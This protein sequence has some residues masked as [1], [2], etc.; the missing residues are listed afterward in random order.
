M[1]TEYHDGV[2]LDELL[3]I[4][5]RYWPLL[6]LSVAICLA[7]TLIYASNLS[8]E[9]VFET[10]FELGYLASSRSRTIA[11]ISLIENDIT[12]RVVATYTRNHKIGRKDL[13]IR[14]VHH[15]HGNLFSLVSRGHKSAA[16]MHKQIH[17]EIIEDVLRREKRAIEEGTPALKERLHVVRAALK[18][19]EA[20]EEAKVRFAELSDATKDSTPEFRSL[21][22]IC[23]PAGQNVDR[24]FSE[25]LLEQLCRPDTLQSRRD[26]AKLVRNIQIDLKRA[27]G[28]R[29]DALTALLRALEAGKNYVTMATAERKAWREYQAF[30]LEERLRAMQT[31]KTVGFTSTSTTSASHPIAR[32]WLLALAIGLAFGMALALVAETL[33][34]RRALTRTAE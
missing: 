32:R 1:T 22:P 26:H 9:R 7:G 24:V 2:S 11:T 19:A 31:G 21:S 5:I 34:Q 10:R 25:D 13:N 28:D 29:F 18:A 20:E 17:R 30:R 14:L 12:P 6:I 27:T 3:R 23:A 15:R 4:F 8:T 16:A 33:R